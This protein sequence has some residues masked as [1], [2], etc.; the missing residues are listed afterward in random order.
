MAGKRSTRRRYSAE[1]KEQI[2][3]ECSEPGASVAAIAVAHG[4]NPN[5]VHHW[6]C[7]ARKHH[8]PPALPAPAAFIPLPMP[9]AAAPSG[10][11]DIRIEL[12]RGPVT[13]TLSWPLAAAAECARFLRETLS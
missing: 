2:L 3:A 12:R 7:A 4:I 1:F 6:R 10:H 9:S 5:V 11:G 8:E 13:I